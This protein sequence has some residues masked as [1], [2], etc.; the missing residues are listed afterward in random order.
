MEGYVKNISG[1]PQYIMKRQVLPGE[2]ISA[3][4]LEERYWEVSGAN[5]VHVFVR[6]LRKFV[7]EGTAAWEINLV[8][9]KGSKAAIHK[10]MSK[11]KEVKDVVEN[12][13][14]EK[15]KQQVINRGVVTPK[16]TAAELVKVSYKKCAEL[17]AKCSDEKV[18]KEALQK[19]STMARKEKTCQVLRDRLLEL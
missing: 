12:K 6:W 18:L 15:P 11:T 16:I 7:F 9:E 13:E 4:A 3:K 5:T 19:A 10:N 2:T 1:V 17:A 14:E 8:D